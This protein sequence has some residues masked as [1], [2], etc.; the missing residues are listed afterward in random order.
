MENMQ[1]VP[2]SVWDRQLRSYKALGMHYTEILSYLRVSS[3][4]FSDEVLDLIPG[5]EVFDDIDVANPA[6]DVTPHRLISA[7]ITDR[8]VA[9]PPFTESLANLGK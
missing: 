8:G 4:P 3:I 2:H 9:Y 1:H 6:F 5:H 7:I